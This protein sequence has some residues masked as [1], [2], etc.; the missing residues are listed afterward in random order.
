[1][2]AL[3][4]HF[5]ENHDSLC[6][7][8]LVICFHVLGYMAI[9]MIIYEV[10][11]IHRSTLTISQPSRHKTIFTGAI[12]AVSSFMPPLV[13]MANGYRQSYIHSSD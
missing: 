8:I 3:I 11:S 7:L 2:T 1:M 6:P 12:L 5:H 4:N 10:W 13:Q 9:F